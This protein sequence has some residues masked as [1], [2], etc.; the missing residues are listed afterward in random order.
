MLRAVYKVRGFM[1]IL[2]KAASRDIGAGL[3]KVLLEKGAGIIN[4]APLPADY[5]GNTPLD[6]AVKK[7]YWDSVELLLA[8][9]LSRAAPLRLAVMKAWKNLASKMPAMLVKFLDAVGIER[10]TKVQR[11]PMC[12][13]DEILVVLGSQM[14]STDMTKEVAY[15]MFSYKHPA[16]WIRQFG[17]YGVDPAN[18][19]FFRFC[20]KVDWLAVL[21]HFFKALVRYFL[22]ISIAPYEVGFCA[23]PYVAL[24][25][26]SVNDSPLGALVANNVYDAFST[27]AIAAV[28][29]YKWDMYAGK[30]YRRQAVGYC[31]FMALY[32]T[33]TTIGLEWYPSVG[34][35]ADMYGRRGWSTRMV[36][37]FLLELLLLLGSIWYLWRELRQ[38]YRQGAFQYAFGLNSG[39]NWVE[40]F[41]SLMVV[42]VLLLQ[43]LGFEE[44]RWVMSAC[45]M[46]L[47]IR[48]LQGR[49][50]R[51]VSRD[52]APRSTTS[53]QGKESSPRGASPLPLL[54]RNGW[55]SRSQENPKKAKFPTSISAIPP[56]PAVQTPNHPQ[57]P[58]QH[59]SPALPNP[60]TSALKLR[61]RPPPRI[62]SLLLQPIRSGGLEGTGIYVQIIIRIITDL[63]P[64]LLIVAITLATY[65]FAFQQFIVYYEQQVANDGGGS[66]SDKFT[67][68]FNGFPNSFLSVYYFMAAGGIEKDVGG[69]AKYVWYLHAMLISFSFFVSIILLNLLIATMS[70]SYQ[71]VQKHAKQEWMLLKAKLILDI[72]SVL[73]EPLFKNRDLSAPKWLYVFKEEDGNTRQ[74]QQHTPPDAV[75]RP[76][77]RMHLRH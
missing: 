14:D 42:L 37:R 19:S 41:S 66:I 44:A 64:F 70:T 17:A 1:S 68:L 60:P 13:G 51:T 3:L 6:L 8:N 63:G 56:N 15:D 38:M 45:T 24:T 23:L 12:W 50:G 53:P 62:T 26:R 43:V 18:L 54:D 20:A 2:P 22:R 36:L 33:T 39:W 10:L 61:F 46:L 65:T 29:T 57:P 35:L 11:L 48:M 27:D 72:D 74:E 69:E 49:Y 73:P 5:Q 58:I 21:W 71:E 28:I 9:E 31:F 30:I 52:P 67:E 7:G 32:I 76:S 40:V 75:H 47:G 34:R 16:M 55:S 77:T 59:P 4:S 25:T